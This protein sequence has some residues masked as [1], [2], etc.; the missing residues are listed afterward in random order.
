MSAAPVLDNC[1]C[2]DTETNVPAIYNRPGL[3]ALAY[4]I[5]THPDILARMLARLPLQAVTD[6]FNRLLYPLKSLTARDDDDPAIAL[7]D[8]WATVA[9]VLTFYQERIANEGY[10]RTATER[11][12]ILELAREIGYELRPGVAAS[13]F[14]AFTVDDA[15]GA[16]N[17]VTVPQST[18]VQSVPGR[19]ELPQT[20][21]TNADIVARVEWNILRPRL[22]QPQILIQNDE[23]QV[24][25]VYLAG[26]TNS[27]KQGD[28]LLLA[29]KDSTGTLQVQTAHIQNVVVDDK[30]K[31]TQVDL[32]PNP[33]PP[34]AL[35]N[36]VFAEGE[37]SLGDIALTGSAVT[38]NIRNR[39]WTES[40]LNAFFAIQ[41]WLPTAVVTYIA[42]PPRPETT[43]G[44][45]GVYAFRARAGFFGHNAPLHYTLPSTTYQRGNQTSPPPADPYPNDWDD[46]GKETT[47]WTD[48]QKNANTDADVFLERV[49]PEV[50][51]SSW[52]VFESRD[53]PPVAYRVDV[54]TELSRADY[55]MSGRTTG[56]VLKQKDGTTDPDTTVK[57]KNRKTTAYVQSEQ[58]TLADLPVVDPIAAGSTSLQLDR[59]VLGLQIGQ[60]LALS[61]ERDD[62]PGVV[63]TEI[64]FL[65]DIIHSG[66]FTTLVFQNVL[67]AGLQ[68]SYVRNTVT[69]NANVAAATH[70]ETVNEVLG[71]GNGAQANQRFVLK[72]PPLTY[73]SA[74]TPSGTLSTL[75]VRVN[76][77]WWAE[78]PTLYGLEARDEEYIVRIGD[79]GATSIL[80]GDGEMGARLP[81]GVENVVA[82]Y[83]SGIG[84]S[85]M[86]AADKLT[87]LQ[88]RPP[89]IRNV[90]NPV[91]TSGAADPE[92]RDAARTNA[93]LT[94]LTMDRIVSLRDFQDFARGFAGIG[95]ARAV[96]LWDNG[97]PF[98]HMT[99]A[100]AAATANDASSIATHVVE[101]AAPLYTNLVAAVQAASDPSQIV[102]VDSYQPIF[103]NLKAA[104]AV[105]ARY[106][107]ADVLAGVQSALI[108]AFSFDQRDFAQPV[109][110][111]E[112]VTVIQGVSGVIASD[113]NQLYRIDDPTGP[114]QQ[115]PSPVLIAEPTRWQDGQILLAQL[116]LLNPAG[117]N[118]SEG[119]L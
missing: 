97:T 64:I 116:L 13:A 112:I 47:I 20:F 75:K 106:V 118:L 54:A 22:T 87:L 58:L 28:L 60:A 71:S 39:M 7:L 91:P 86:V 62:L 89:G 24:T 90:T 70:G 104:L 108:T 96:A 88:T 10:L 53:V 9:D 50:V 55:G 3:L 36:P 32:M 1:G 59:M 99:I 38:D 29:A 16:L 81:S 8:A 93:P 117:V 100:S 82:T 76:G 113:L 33:P 48:S 49:V 4:R 45:E 114:Q 119:K 23:L 56:L 73:V 44:V 14:L 103:F 26:T 101:P 95:K 25:T 42:A 79:D 37:I 52:A 69:L 18:K 61:G 51:A 110:A 31:R 67:Q 111:A 66:G 2:C 46:P 115:K 15:A 94:V 21:E 12:S 102:R 17:I 77:V 43:P 34:P 85:G 5:G 30:L 74:A 27:L 57:F 68:F 6:D 92:S 19:G 35:E 78:S 109:T 63:S 65:T 107:A 11:R 98:V 83:R 72:R 80:F 84:S 41:G 105:D 40:R